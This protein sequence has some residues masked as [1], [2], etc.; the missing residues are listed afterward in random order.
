MPSARQVQRLTAEVVAETMARN[1]RVVVDVLPNENIIFGSSAA[2][3]ELRMRIESALGSQSPFLLLGESGTGKQLVARYVHASSV[4]KEMPF[5]RIG[6]SGLIPE[7]LESELFGYEQGAFPDIRDG[8]R[9]LVEVAEGGTLFISQI[10]NMDLR[11]QSKLFRLLRDGKYCRVG[12]IV[13][14]RADVR[15]ICS[16]R[17]EL[18]SEVNRGRF[19]QD[20][21]CC[22]GAL[23]FRPAA[24][25]DRKEDIPLLWEFF[26]ER[27]AKKFKKNAPELPTPILQVLKEWCWPGNLR[28]LEN[29]VARV[30]ILSDAETLAAELRR[31]L[32][33]NQGNS[34]ASAPFLV[35]ALDGRDQDGFLELTTADEDSS[36]GVWEPKKVVKPPFRR[37]FQTR[38]KGSTVYR[39]QDP[40]E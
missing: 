24:L 27:M 15:I 26:A 40:P 22:I 3:Q 16:T 7:I 17:L 33:G 10:E 14:R 29:G 19:R 39:P 31:K 20:L 1:Q 5:V 8:K 13:E 32:A 18:A 38:R 4:R 35:R 9:G 6:C 34:H 11:V 21:F 30:V 2:M 25:R 37:R 12:G 23:S 28:E 36:R